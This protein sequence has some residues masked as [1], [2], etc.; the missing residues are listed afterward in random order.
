METPYKPMQVHATYTHTYVAHVYIYI[1]ECMRTHPAAD[2]SKY[3]HANTGPVLP[4]LYA[5][6]RP[7][8]LVGA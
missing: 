3:A 5:R 1:C 2:G 7:K 4:S 6:L 8:M